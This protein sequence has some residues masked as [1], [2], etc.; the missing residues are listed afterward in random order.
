MKIASR[1]IIRPP[2]LLQIWS[3]P[4]FWSSHRWVSIWAQPVTWTPVTT[5]KPWCQKSTQ[6]QPHHHTITSNNI[7]RSRQIKSQKSAPDQLVA[8]E[9]TAALTKSWTTPTR[10]FKM[11]RQIK[12]PIKEV[13]RR[14]NK[15]RLR[16]RFWSSM[17]RMVIS[18]KCL[19]NT[20]KETSINKHSTSRNLT[21][22][23]KRSISASLALRM[24]MK[25]LISI[26]ARRLAI[27]TKCTNRTIKS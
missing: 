24:M 17:R 3:R 27:T 5:K 7:T 11:K 21:W 25:Q 19:N 18:P 16:S 1:K 13:K 9:A 4:N 8:K 26:L 15:H 2:W 10:T 22:S 14:K 20:S 12:R 6:Y 23:K